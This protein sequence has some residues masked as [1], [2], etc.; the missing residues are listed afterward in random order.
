TSVKKIAV[1]SLKFAN[2]FWLRMGVLSSAEE[3]SLRTSILNKSGCIA[4]G[5]HIM[6][7]LLR[8]LMPHLF[9]G[10]SQI[11]WFPV[12]AIFVHSR[13]ELAD[14]LGRGLE[15]EF[16]HII[17]IYVVIG[18]LRRGVEEVRFWHLIRLQAL[19]QPLIGKIEPEL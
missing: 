6:P 19:L 3:S 11:G 18:F 5:F 15:L 13:L 12:G 4:E 7:I 16:R 8:L 10:L 9:F 1:R 2:R 17:N 14:L